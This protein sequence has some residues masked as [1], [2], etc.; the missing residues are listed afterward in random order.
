[1]FSFKDSSPIHRDPMN[2]DGGKQGLARG[3]RRDAG[4]EGRGIMDIVTTAHCRRC[5]KSRQHKFIRFFGDKA[6]VECCGCLTV[7]IKNLGDVFQDKPRRELA[8]AKA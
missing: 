3:G 7:G 5:G 6:L 2:H 1:M 4:P 8:G